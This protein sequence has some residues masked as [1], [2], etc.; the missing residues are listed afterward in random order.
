MP[1]IKQESV[2]SRLERYG[3]LVIRRRILREEETQVD[4]E[5]HEI[6]AALK[7]GG[8]PRLA[9]K[10]AKPVKPVK[11]AKSETSAISMKA[12]PQLDGLDSRIRQVQKKLITAL[13]SMGGEGHIT[14]LAKKMDITQAAAGA[15]LARAKR[16]GIVVSA[17]RGTY[18]LVG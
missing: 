5:L 6:V 11:L 9:A 2:E 1:R 14:A 8:P 3:E 12:V 13:R 17:S 15:R 16:L 18:K 10:P 7:G 4:A